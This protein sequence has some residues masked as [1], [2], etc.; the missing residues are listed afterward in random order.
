[1]LRV[2]K[3]GTLGCYGRWP[4]G[5]GRASVI[6]LAPSW[7]LWLWRSARIDMPRTIYSFTLFLLL[8]SVS[9]K[10]VAQMPAPITGAPFEATRIVN[11]SS[12]TGVHTTL[13]TVA[14][15][16]DGSAYLELKNLDGTGEIVIRDVLHQQTIELYPKYHMFSVWPVAWKAQTRPAE[17]TQQYFASAGV[18]G[19]KRVVDGGLEIT[20]IGRR[21]IEGVETI[22][23]SEK[24]ADG[25][26]HQ[27]WYSPALDLNIESK[28]HD[29]AKEIDSETQIQQVRLG[30]PDAKLFAIPA[31]YVEHK[32]DLN[33]T[34]A[35]A[36]AKSTR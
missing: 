24:A 13:G 5:E 22:G 18:S 8:A 16:S 17:Y 10:A 34:G 20:T 31:G 11:T 30:E 33:I 29:P 26:I 15:R 7:W 9:Y 21:K 4:L 6:A 2:T 12:P 27:R 1:M 3:L 35:A 25:R 36:T 28:N 23:F 32:G 19:S 14:R